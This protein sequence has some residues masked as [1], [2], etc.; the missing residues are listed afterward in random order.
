MKKQTKII[1]NNKEELAGLLENLKYQPSIFDGY[2]ETP[3]GNKGDALCWDLIEHIIEKYFTDVIFWRSKDPDLMD[4][5]N[6]ITSFFVEKNNEMI[7]H[8]KVFNENI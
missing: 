8:L 7:D 6:K 4:R 2:S 3:E 5:F 1:I